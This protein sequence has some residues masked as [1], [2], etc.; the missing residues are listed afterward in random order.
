MKVINEILANNILIASIISNIFAQFLKVVFTYIIEKRWDWQL[1]I[2]T[3]GK[4]SSHTATVTT[5]TVLLGAKY[6][7]N[8]PYFAIAFIFSSIVIV[9]AVSVRKEVGK[10]A[11]VL[12]E[13]FFETSIGKRL[14]DLLEIEVFKELIGH[15]FIEVL[16]GFLF[17]LLVS[18]VDIVWFLK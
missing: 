3:G 6:G 11:E 13:I 17:G 16:M 4:P 1:L 5:L 8:S 15:S 12:N 14:R 7:F 10:H 9:D 2:S 18:I